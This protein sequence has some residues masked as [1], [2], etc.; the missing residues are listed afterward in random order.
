MGKLSRID[1]DAWAAGLFEGEGWIHIPSNRS[2]R[3]LVNIGLGM[4]DRDI[5]S[6]FARWAKCG[7]I[8]K[9]VRPYPYKTMWRWSNIR[10]EDNQRVL[11][12]LLPFFGSRRT[13]KAK[14][15][16]KI[17]LLHPHRKRGSNKCLKGHLLKG[18]NAMKRHGLNYI[19]CRIC[20][21]ALQRALYHK[22]HPKAVYRSI[23][24]A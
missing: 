10:Y 9:Y 20:Q 8:Y 3:R 6:R 5:V 18:F 13:A 24:G 7:Q 21:R 15:A 23:S 2:N 16:L 19:T 14:Q 17:K 12:L 1:S 11:R 4:T 22:K